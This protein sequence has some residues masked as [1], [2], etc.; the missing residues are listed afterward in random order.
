[1]ANLYYRY[2]P[3]TCQYERIL[4]GGKKLLKQI[5]VYFLLSTLVAIPA[6]GWYIHQY[7]SL[8]E[9]YLMQEN[10]TLLAE[11]TTLQD[12]I[13]DAYSSLSEFNR[14]DDQYYR[15]LLDLSP[16]SPSIREAG[17]GG[18]E[19]K[20]NDVADH[21]LVKE[22][23]ERLE[24]LKHQVQV[25]L[26]SF[27]E[28]N[29]KADIQL[30]KR[31]SRPAIL[32]IHRKDLVH[33][34]TTFGNRFHPLLRIWRDHRGLDMTAPKGAPVFATGNG[35]VSRADYSETYGLVIYIDHGFGYETRYAHLLKYELKQGQEVKRGQ[36]VGYVGT[37]GQSDAY[38]LHY[39]VL[40]NG[41]QVNPINFFQRDLSHQE[42]QKI[43]QHPKYKPSGN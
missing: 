31:A 9:Q 15:T 14:K 43:V 29:L 20:L 26:Q 17:V 23:Y 21:A 35:V 34:H 12:E 38:H 3:E 41:V 10:N 28:L 19:R 40:H 24:K 30:S 22:S 5:A 1:M 42:Y 32:P 39:E 16:L 33:L 2:N 37:T 36:L 18:I 6:T 4:P 7:S 11:W 25:E 27:D 8:Q 13:D